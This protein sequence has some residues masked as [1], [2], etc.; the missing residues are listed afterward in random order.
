MM[1]VYGIIPI[2]YAYYAYYCARPPDVADFQHADIVAWCKEHDPTRVHDLT[3]ATDRLIKVID[4]FIG[5]VIAR[6]EV[7]GFSAG[8]PD[9]FD[10]KDVVAG[11]S[12][13][14]KDCTY[15]DANTD[16]K[17]NQFIEEH[18]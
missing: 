14:L 13:Y 1:K 4:I 7:G 11:A 18:T 10:D 15:V 6:R 8:K 16:A 12:I 2:Y 17:L 3:W 5:E 9:W